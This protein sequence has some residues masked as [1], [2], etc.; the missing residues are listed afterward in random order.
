MSDPDPTS[1]AAYGHW[2]REHVRFSDTDLVGHVNNVSFA[3]YVETGRVAFVGHCFA[4]VGGPGMVTLR[5]LE[6]D[7]RS[8]LHY[9]AELDVG[10]RLLAIGRTSFTVG[11][12]VF[13]GDRC[14]ATAA[15]VMVAVGPDGAVP[16]TGP[17]RSALEAALPA[18][19]A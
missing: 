16:L 15:A 19:E 14:A 1:P 6:I 17:T 4:S 18:S 5:R 8:E 10:S 9:P 12:G 13:V 2:V 7:Y 3:S 11:T